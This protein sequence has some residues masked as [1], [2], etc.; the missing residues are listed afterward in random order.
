MRKCWT[1]VVWC[2]LLTFPASAWAQV[3]FELLP[4]PIQT[5]SNFALSK[6]GKAMA[7]NYGGE[8]FS[9]TSSGGFVDLGLGDIFNSSIGISAHGK[10]IVSGRYGSDR[11]SNPAIWEAAKSWVDLGQPAESCIL[12]ARLGCRCGGD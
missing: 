6:D 7:A 8:I 1:R 12:H 9:W 2:A 11:N 10:T 3:Q 4:D 5:W